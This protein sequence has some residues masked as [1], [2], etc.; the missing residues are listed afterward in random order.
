MGTY[1]VKGDTY[2]QISETRFN[3]N[4]GH[5]NLGYASRIPTEGGFLRKE[6]LDTVNPAMISPKLELRGVWVTTVRNTDF[7]SPS[8]FA[9]DSFDI[10]LFKQEY[11]RIVQHCKS[12]RLNAIFFQVR[13]EGDAF[14]PSQLNPWSQ[15]LTGQQGLKPDWGDFDPL[16]WVIETTHSEGIEFHAWF[17]PYRLTPSIY[18][19]AT[20]ESLLELLSEDN[21][22]RRHPELT[23][24][25][26]G[27]L[28]LNP[29]IPEVNQ[30]MARTIREVLDHYHVDAIHLDDYFYPYSFQ[31]Q[32]DDQLV[33]VSFADESPDYETYL[34]Y[35]QGDQTI[36]QW[37]EY[38][39][40]NL[41]YTLSRT[42]HR[43]NQEANKSVA[44]GISPFGIWANAEETGGV[45][46]QT[47]TSQLSSLN[48]YVN[49]K[50]WVDS[51]WL[52]YIAPQNYWSSNDPLSPFSIVA[53]WWDQV[54][55]AS[56]T[57]L[58]M[59]LGLYLYEEDANNPSWQNPEE[60]PNQIRYIRTLKNNKGYIFFT[61]HNLIPDRAQTTALE[62]ALYPIAELQEDF[63]LV[64][65]RKRLQ[66]ENTP[67]VNNLT[68]SRGEDNFNL[69]TFEDNPMGMS[70]YYVIYRVPGA[71]DQRIDISNANYIINVIG[72][73]PGQTIQIYTDD[74]ADPTKTY[75]YAVTALS[76]A[77]V[78]SLPTSVV[79][80]G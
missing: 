23:Y 71:T 77:Q 20:K 46:S 44:F 76:Q 24:M 33:F 26:N 34:Q 41:V 75:T 72:K 12:L 42:V 39:I 6:T 45:G 13:P 32:V 55:E 60:I 48:E 80:R 15:Y 17:N 78:E 4:Q 57:Q 19:G 3:Q 53:K 9:N 68:I 40:N 28:F 70:Q 5:S 1:F 58:Y 65:P 11:L 36:N 50:L 16:A 25:F 29:G 14:Y 30:F 10:D 8:V 35:R 22:A 54:V 59:G 51:G 2:H 74:Q 31:T 49:S 64:P 69:L 18:S 21:F 38:N 37:R 67:P 79:C 62:Q 7:P 66:A 27:Q 47:S 52:D 56:A 63:S 61:Y 73:M 43:Y